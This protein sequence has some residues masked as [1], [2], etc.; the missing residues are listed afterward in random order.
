MWAGLGWARLTQCISG[1]LGISR[2]RV[3]WSYALGSALSLTLLLKE[4]ESPVMSSLGKGRGT[5]EPL[6]FIV[7][8]G[9]EV[10]TTVLMAI[11]F[12]F[13]K[14]LI[15][16]KTK[17]CLDLGHRVKAMG[18]PFLVL[19]L[20]FTSRAP[21]PHHLCQDPCCKMY[22]LSSPSCPI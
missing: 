19:L 7:S 22:T 15:L 20:G 12:S 10:S 21:E 16:R 18:C 6:H 5:S 4:Q 9:C 11:F 8:L 1:W 13:H 3:H 17:G 14:A 2:Y